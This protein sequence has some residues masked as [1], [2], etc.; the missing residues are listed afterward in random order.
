METSLAMTQRHEYTPTQVIE[1]VKSQIITIQNLMKTIMKDGEHF[2]KIPGC[3]DKPTL[4]K[5]GAEKLGFTFKLAPKFSGTDREDYI[6][7]RNGHREWVVKCALYHIE[8]G[9]FHGEGV[10]SCSTLEGKYRYRWDKTDNE[11]PKEYWENRDPDIL[12]GTQFTAR[13]SGKKWL[14]YQKVEHDN[15]ADYYNTILKMAKKRAH[16]DAM[17][18]ATAASDIFTQDLEDLSE[19]TNGNNGNGEKTET[20]ETSK[21][22]K[23]DPKKKAGMFDTIVKRLKEMAS[24]DVGE[25][26]TGAFTKEKITDPDMVSKVGKHLLQELIGLEHTSE[27]KKVE[28]SEFNKHYGTIKKAYDEWKEK[29]EQAEEIT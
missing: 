28:H 25:D 20:F 18:T 14:I 15:P 10:G 21:P 7:L 27:L 29:L 6:E 16:V 3:G 12:G 24:W 11:V 22:K 1:Q 23:V 4:L 19:E 2:G 9:N 26:V 8:T 5:P 17:L 13:K